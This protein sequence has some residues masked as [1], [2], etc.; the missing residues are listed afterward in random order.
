[1]ATISKK[2]KVK[3]E[4]GS[5]QEVLVASTSDQIYFT[6]N[7]TLETK[8]NELV[9]I[10]E[11]LRID[12]DTIN[13]TTIP[14]LKQELNNKDTELQ[15]AINIINDTTIPNL[16]T[17]LSEI[18][19]GLQDAINTINTDIEQLQATDSSLTNDINGLSS[20]ASL[21]AEQIAEL[22]GAVGDFSSLEENN[23]LVTLIGELQNQI[24]L[25][26]NRVSLLENPPAEEPVDP[27]AP[28]DPV[29]PETPTDPE[30]GGETPTEPTE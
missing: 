7:K 5:F 27:D 11:G 8:Y 18:D 23:T 15:N 2:F 14:N 6:D 9:S 4:D 10:D 12:V 30:E 24:L 29:E 1:M 26:E 19:K 20:S 28:T 22:Q 17:E 21:A 16:K 3:Q 25:L 13:N